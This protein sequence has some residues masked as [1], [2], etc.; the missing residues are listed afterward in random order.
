MKNH[1]FS[2]KALILC[3]V[4]VSSLIFY[5][6]SHSLGGSDTGGEALNILLLLSQ[7]NVWELLFVVYCYIAGSYSISIFLS[8]LAFTWEEC[9]PMVH[10]S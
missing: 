4:K 3:L 1:S 10:F 9:I 5:D 7:M 2:T 6:S 8:S